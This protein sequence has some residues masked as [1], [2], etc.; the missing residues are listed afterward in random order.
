M[1]LGIVVRI[2]AF[3]GTAFTKIPEWL[4]LGLFL[5]GGLRFGV[6]LV[7]LSTRRWGKGFY[8]GSRWWGAW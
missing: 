4:R 2:T 5:V 3:L 7:I 8:N 6:A 1:F